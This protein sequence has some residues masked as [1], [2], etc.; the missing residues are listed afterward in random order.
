[1][2][3]HWKKSLAALLIWP[4]LALSLEAQQL[5]DWQEGWMDIHHIAT[6]Q[7]DCILLILPDGTTWVLDAGDTGWPKGDNIEWYKMLPDD[8][9]PVGE[10]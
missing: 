4:L 2:H 5:P 1:M 10:Y 8:S 3:K 6:S 7:G 9:K